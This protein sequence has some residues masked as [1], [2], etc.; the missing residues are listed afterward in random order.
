MPLMKA[1]PNTSV[2]EQV[3]MAP[4]MYPCTAMRSWGCNFWQPTNASRKMCVENFEKHNLR[5]QR[6]VPPEKL[7]VYN[8]DDG[9]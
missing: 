3:D 4:Y 2:A 8:W 7:L 5:V 6:V 9:W 1:A